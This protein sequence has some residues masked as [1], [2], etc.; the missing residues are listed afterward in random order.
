MFPCT[1]AREIEKWGRKWRC[2][3]V[4]LSF[5]MQ[6]K[7]WHK[8]HVFSVPFMTTTTSN[9]NNNTHIATF[10]YLA[11]ASAL[12]CIPALAG[13]YAQWRGYRWLGF[14]CYGLTILSFVLFLI[15]LVG[16][17]LLR[18]GTPFLLRFLDRLNHVL[19]PIVS[20]IAKT[21]FVG[22]AIGMVVR[23][24]FF[25]WF[26]VLLMSDQLV[27]ALLTRIV[28]PHSSQSNYCK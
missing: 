26:L 21:S 23:A 20:R 4:S 16:F 12:S 8:S 1:T 25:V 22:P 5:G 3:K 6:L 18:R 17:K 14:F 13:F 28:G 10:L 11:I 9:S 7:Q 24:N 19:A 27:R 2:Y 15:L